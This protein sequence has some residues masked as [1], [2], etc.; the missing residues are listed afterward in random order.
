[1]GEAR[2]SLNQAI[3][4]RSSPKALRTRSARQGVATEASF[5]RMITACQPL[6]PGAGRAS[7]TLLIRASMRR[8]MEATIKLSNNSWRTPFPVR[9]GRVSTPLDVP[10]WPQCACSSE[11]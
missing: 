6:A 5:A 9:S 10:Q 7:G 3:S 1:M 11:F 4:L 8:A 2:C